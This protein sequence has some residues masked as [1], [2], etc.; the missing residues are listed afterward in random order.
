MAVCRWCEREMT[1]AS[2]CCV[3]AMHRD[4]VRIP[5]IPWGKEFPRWSSSRE[6]CGD[7]GVAPGGFHHLG[8]D[9]QRC[10]ACGGQMLS[11]GCEFD[12]DETLGDVFIDADGDLSE[13]RRVGDQEVIVH[14]K[15]I[16]EK[17]TTVVDGIP[18]TT[19]LR[20]VI[21]IAVDTE[22]EE[23]AR[24]VRECLDRRLFDASE[25][26]ERIAEDDMRERQGAKIL[27]RTLDAIGT[28]DPSSHGYGV[29]TETSNGP[30]NGS[31]ATGRDSGVQEGTPDPRKPRSGPRDDTEE[32]GPTGWPSNS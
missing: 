26:R 17:D 13:V 20:T 21:D 6:R 31:V 10:A 4:G 15:D 32:D 2:S 24:I 30:S 9:V 19:A 16:P 5:M 8:C 23:L 12:E 18:C 29:E 11:C 1:T 7:C 27:G 22:K 14:Y 25:A 3:D 28:A